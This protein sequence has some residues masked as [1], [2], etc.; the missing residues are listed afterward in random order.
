MKNGK[1]DFRK[2]RKKNKKDIKDKTILLI[3]T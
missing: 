1:N 2:R 3:I